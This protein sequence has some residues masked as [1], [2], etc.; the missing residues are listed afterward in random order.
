MSLPSATLGSVL[1]AQ[2]TAEDARPISPSDRLD[3]Y[4]KLLRAGHLDTMVHALPLLLNLKGKPYVLDDHFPFE[5]IFR[6]R[7]PPA[8]VYKTGRQ[9]SKTWCRYFKDNRVYDIYGRRLRLQDIRVGMQVLTVD[10]TT[11]KVTSGRVTAIHSA[12]PK[13]CYRITTRLGLELH[14]AGTHPLRKLCGWTPA[15]ELKVKDRIAHVACG[16]Q[17][18]GID[19][20]DIRVRLTAYMLGDGSFCGN[21]SFTTNRDTA[22]MA[23]FCSLLPENTYRRYRKANTK[24]DSVVLKRQH[25]LYEWA[26][27]DGLAGKRAH[28]KHIPKWVFLLSKAQTAIFI[29]RLWATDGTLKQDKTKPQISYCTTSHELAYDLK[30]LLLKFRIPCSIKRRKAGY[31]TK[32]GK[33]IACRDVYIVRVETRTGWQR[34]LDTF[35]VPDKPGFVLRDV[36]ANNNRDTVPVEVGELIAD[37]VGERRGTSSAA[38]HQVGLRKKPKHAPTRS[39]LRKYVDFCKTHCTDHH[40]LPELTRLQYGDLLWD[41]ITDVTQIASQPCIDIEVA[42]TH[43]YVVD[44]IWSH[45]STSMAAHGV[46]LSTAI[47]NVTTLYVMPLF[48]QVR[49]FSSMFV[50]PFIDQSPVKQLWTGTETVNSVLH[51][52]FKNNSKMLFSFAFLNAD[53]IRGVSADK[54]AIDEVQDMNHEHIPI[55]RETMSASDLALRQFTGTPKTLDNTLE[56]L[57]QES[58][59]AEWFIPCLHCT[60]DGHPTWNIPTTDHHLERMIGPYHP[61]ISEKHPAT[62]CH[63]CG[64]PISPRLGRWVHRYPERVWEQAGY[65]VPQIIMPLHYSKP[66]KWAELLAKQ[67]GKGNTPANVF[68]NEV[69]GESYDTAAKL[70]TLTELDRVSNIGPNEL[71]LARARRSLYAMTVLAVDWG[72]GGEKQISFTTVAF[73]GV[74]RDGVIE[75]IYGKRLLTPHDHLREAR[76]IKQIWDY[77]RPTL[78]AH[79]YTGAGALRETLLIQAGVPTRAVMPCQYVRSASQQPCYHVAPTMQHPRSHYR[80]DKSRS[81]LLTCAMIKCRRLRFFDADYKSQEDPGLIRDFLALV[82]D[83]VTTM[84]AGEIYRITRQ[85]G[86][87]DDFAQAV[88]LGCV[89]IWYRTRNWPRL[90]EMV[91]YTITDDQLRA[92]ALQSDSDWDD[93]ILDG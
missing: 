20:D 25:A 61:E 17:F 13:P 64:K 31:K 35:D 56:A 70:V 51:R 87:T 60:T 4:N 71:A 32:T 26:Q 24:A 33:Y 85:E 84:A 66:D 59:Q 14:L 68:Y 39:K 36:P 53:R 86:F 92:A 65:H 74:R 80:V 5:E 73:L 47:P 3:A 54:V 76:E 82:E 89:G 22:A 23:E 93:E 28:E 67:A 8:L 50:Q 44:G 63:K 19:A 42:S 7:M 30:S 27:A 79:D 46:V 81:L 45:N 83:K 16:G 18:A 6:F 11:F 41:E 34:F 29:E 38:L 62:I 1:S 43:S 78:L 58:S 37:I 88:N 9:V 77:L 21:Y 69:L 55:I 72:G 2:H 40:R 10:E 48:E 12:A 90:D 91:E 57:W 49:R 75:C 15:K 52:S